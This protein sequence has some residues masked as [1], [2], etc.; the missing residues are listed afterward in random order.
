MSPSPIGNEDVAI[1]R[2]GHMECRPS[3]LHPARL[4]G[5]T[6]CLVVFGRGFGSRYT[7]F[8]KA[9]DHLNH[10]DRAFAFVCFCIFHSG[11]L[12]RVFLFLC[13]ISFAF[14]FSHFCFLFQRQLP[15]PPP[16]SLSLSLCIALFP[17]PRL[18][19]S[20]PQPYISLVRRKRQ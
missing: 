16:P 20:L 18:F 17:L 14:F 9:E 2:G 1:R 6:G 15:A 10:H 8:V 7:M 11:H 12:H 19:L 4:E 13:L 5:N 3:T